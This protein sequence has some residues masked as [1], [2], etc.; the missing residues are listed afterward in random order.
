MVERR[1]YVLTPNGMAAVVRASVISIAW[2][3][4]VLTTP[5]RSAILFCFAFVISYVLIV[6]V[7]WWPQVLS[8][9]LGIVVMFMWMTQ[10]VLVVWTMARLN[11][12][13]F[14]T[15]DREQPADV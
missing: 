10:A 6:D 9:V 2:R 15:A 12:C 8:Q 7:A 14:T 13:Q 11:D 5:S 3:A 1:S 4:V